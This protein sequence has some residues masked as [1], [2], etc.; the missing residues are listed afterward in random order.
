[1]KKMFALALA[2]CATVALADE[3]AVGATAPQFSL[4]NAVDGKTYSFKPGGESL[5]HRLHL[6]LLPLFGRLRE[7]PRVAGL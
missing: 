4:L 6:Q 1:M 3:L 5:G 7:P 2:L